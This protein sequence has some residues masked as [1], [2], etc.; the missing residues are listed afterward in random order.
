MTIHRALAELKL[1]DAKIEKAISSIEPAGIKQQDSLVNNV[2]NF[3]TFTK[4]AKAKYQKITD[5]I[6]RKLM[7]KSAIVTVNSVTEIIVGDKTM[8]IADAINYKTI[9]AAKKDLLS[10]LI[11]KHSD[12]LRLMENNNMKVEENALVLAQTAL[13]NTEIKLS[14]KDAVAVTK[15]FIDANTFD[16]VD[17]LGIPALSEKMGDEILEFETEIDATLSEVNAITT[18]TI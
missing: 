3:E 2:A 1:I 15:P 14:D 16:L 9:I 13:G 6:E 5:L 10:M 7:I 18:I 8:T 4:D 11:K 17:P 12:S